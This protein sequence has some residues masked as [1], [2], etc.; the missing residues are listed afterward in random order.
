MF[1][2]SDDY[3]Q[4]I[5]EINGIIFC[6][7]D[8]KPEYDSVA[9]HLST[10][11]DE[12]LPDIVKVMIPELIN[13]YGEA[14]SNITVEETIEKLGKPLIDLELSLIN[15]PNQTFD[16]EHIISVEYYGDFEKIYGFC[17]DG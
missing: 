11:Y 2:Y 1:V 8:I 13:F 6:C 9:E 14:I 7:D 12:K 4:N 17:V 10:I 3:L 16:N 5:R 15:Y